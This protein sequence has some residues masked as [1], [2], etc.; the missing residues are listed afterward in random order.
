M[1]GVSVSTVKRWVDAGELRACRTVGKHRMISASEVLRFAQSREMPTADPVGAVE[2]PEALAAALG[3]GRDG[4]A[5]SIVLS[6]ALA[7][8]DAAALADELIRPAMERIGLD[9]E[10]GVLDVF[11]EHRA[12]RVVESAVIDLIHRAP[13]AQPG[14]PLALGASAEGDPYTLP[15]LLAELTLRGLGWEAINLG[16]SLPMASLARA[17]RTLR[18]RLA[19]L[20]ADH[21]ADPGRFAAEFPAVADAAAGSGTA[22]IVG[23]RA[24]GPALRAV[25]EE[26]HATP[27][28]RMAELRD[29]ARRL[30]ADA[31]APGPGTPGRSTPDHA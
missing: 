29:L 18:P 7:G 23:G 8:G 12:T 27:A 3:Q 11:Q 4:E 6:A 25:V 28:G 26:N 17:I 24:L 22:L 19:W 16:T 1:L 9:W 2:G 31:A 14:A 20:S 21:P 13:A 15:G 10:A 5:R 30:H